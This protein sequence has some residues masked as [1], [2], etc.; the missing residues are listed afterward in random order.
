MIFAA[1]VFV[2]GSFGARRT[3]L[4]DSPNRE[5]RN[6]SHL[7]GDLSTSLFFHVLLLGAPQVDN[8]LVIRSA[9]VERSPE[10]LPLSSNIYIYRFQPSRSND[11]IR[12][13]RGYHCDSILARIRIVGYLDLFTRVPEPRVSQISFAIVLFSPRQCCRLYSAEQFSF[14]GASRD[15]R[16]V[17]IFFLHVGETSKCGRVINAIRVGDIYTDVYSRGIKI[18]NLRCAREDG[19]FICGV[20]PR[21]KKNNRLRFNHRCRMRRDTVSLVCIFPGDTNCESQR[22]RYVQRRFS[23]RSSV[24]P[25]HSTALRQRHVYVA[26]A[27][28]VP[29][30]S[31]TILQ[32]R[33]DGIPDLY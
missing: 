14:R 26:P 7:Y 3:L 24:I 19:D 5:N 1:I 15:S 25:G 23:N 21:E 28:C 13:S 22:V 20:I 8:F 18:S 2:E 11:E 29:T 12:K 9:L 17:I 30:D 27:F 32:S 16:L 31:F 6:P 33:R 4:R 10:I